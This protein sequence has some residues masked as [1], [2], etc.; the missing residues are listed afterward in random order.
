MTRHTIRF[1][2]EN[3]E[4]TVAEG[5]S[6]LQA[7]PL[8]G[9]PVRASCGGKGTCG[10]CRMIVREGA[11]R[12][13][14]TGKLSPAELAA[15][16]VLA[17]QTFPEEGV[18]VEVPEETRLAKHQVLLADGPE[19][20]AGALPELDPLFQKIPL[21]LAVPTLEYSPDDAGNLLAALR[22]R[23]GLT[24][25]RIDYELIKELPLIVRQGDWR[26]TVSVADLK[27]CPEG[28]P[29]V[30]A[31]APGWKKESYYGLA[32]DVGTTTVVA[33][34]VELGTGRT[35]AVKGA[36]NQQAVYGDDVISRIVYAVEQKNGREALQKAVVKT[37]NELIGQLL[38]QTGLS[39]QDIYAVVCAGNT[40]MTH[41]LLGIYPDYL[42]LEPYTPG[43]F[44]PPPVS[45]AGLGLQVNDRA[46]VYC[47][48]AI[49]SYVGGDVIAGARVIAIDRAEELTLF[50]DVGTNGEMVLGN[51]EWLLACACS[52]GPAFEGS[53]LR[54]GMRA[55]PGAIERVEIDPATGEPAY[56]TVGYRK[57]LGIC[58][59]GLIDLLSA[60]LE[61]GLIDRSGQFQ[62]SGRTP[63]LREGEEGPEYVLV[64]AEEAGSGQDIVISEAEIK[65]LLRS[66]AAIFAGIKTML[67]K[68][69]IPLEAIEQVYIAGG[70]GRYINIRD[71]VAIGMFPDLPAEKYR[72]IGNSSLKGAK[73]VLLSRRVRDEVEELAKKITYLELSAGKDFFDEF[74]SAMFLPHTDLSL[75]PSL[76]G[77]GA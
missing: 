72:Y 64:W 45:A 51:R 35:A 21:Q 47:L 19:G 69:A 8:A 36:Y 48:P 40:T 2:P 70:F 16:H 55:T 67:K 25:V 1:L 18:V 34:L 20:E 62:D 50:I 14:Q 31:V 63:R 59:S 41:L 29:K 4:V 24:D 49:A 30:V 28:C 26:V 37:I 12:Q 68:V 23:T 7:A 54:H 33:A 32:V 5:E 66:K 17:C 57:P 58:G 38:A 60:L 11:V 56:H 73:M 77:Q 61:A 22:Q 53:G 3:Q 15:G 39:R 10:R 46:Q 75:F 74:V 65:N 76:A 27:G 44:S 52:A 13:V 71:A 6:F 42:R 43:V 9:I